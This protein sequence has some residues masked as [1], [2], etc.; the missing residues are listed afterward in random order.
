LLI[1]T[2]NAAAV[3]G[4]LGFPCI[5][6][7]PDGAFSN[8][9]VKVNGEQELRVNLDALL[10]GSAIVIAQEFLP[11]EF[12]WRVG[13]LNRHALFVCRYYMAHG[14]WQIIR[15]KENGA[16]AEGRTEAFAIGE[17]PDNVI[18]IAVKAASL[19]GD[20]FYGVDLKQIGRRVVVIEI[21]DNPNVDAGNEDGVLKDA[22]YREIMGV[23]RKRI[24]ANKGAEHEG[25]KNE[26][27]A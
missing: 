24:E 2:D 7:K 3:A 12:D 19:I 10:T 14:H 27:A 9:V 17:V 20:G 22:L 16:S 26:R 6:K 15:H 4:S 13:V 21:N 1:Q 5:L 11:T 18:E 8:G 23:F 25:E